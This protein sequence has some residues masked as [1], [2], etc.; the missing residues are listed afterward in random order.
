M[1]SPCKAFGGLRQ[2]A[3]V[4]RRALCRSGNW[5]HVRTLRERGLIVLLG[6]ALAN[7]TAAFRAGVRAQLRG[8]FP[9][10]NAS[11]LGQAAPNRSIERT[12]SSQLRWPAA[13]A[14]VER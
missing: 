2:L 9:V 1:L 14:H 8:A 5:P 10:A 7:R 4:E 13:A 3:F 6:S 11:A 12:S